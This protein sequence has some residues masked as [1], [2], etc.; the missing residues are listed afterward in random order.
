M[1]RKLKVEE[2]QCKFTP[3]NQEWCKFTATMSAVIPENSEVVFFTLQS[4]RV[5]RE[6]A[7][8]VDLRLDEV[9]AEFFLV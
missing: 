6:I 2:M 8:R 5:G 4:E 9:D 7:N 1:E 3:I